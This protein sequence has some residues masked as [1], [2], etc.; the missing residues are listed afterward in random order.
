MKIH[1]LLKNVLALVLGLF[2]GSAINMLIVTISPHIIPPPANADV[3]TE[4]GLK[5]SIHLFQPI[6][7][8]MPFLAHSIGTFVGAY[9]AAKLASS[10][11]PIFA[12]IIGI[13]F[14]SGGIYMVTQLP[15]PLWFN[16]LDLGLAYI[17]AAWLAVKLAVN[18]N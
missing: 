13:F 4:E 3:T 12:L 7:F 10:H 17:P 15:S 18:K 14:L 2:G 8:L 16:I 1:P 6:H 9:I 5:Q 11:K